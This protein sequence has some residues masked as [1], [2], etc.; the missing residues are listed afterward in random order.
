MTT[1]NNR[2]S[3]SYRTTTRRISRRTQRNL[4]RGLAWFIA[5]VIRE[6]LA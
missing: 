5:M 1:V 3:R 6:V 2:L 4:I